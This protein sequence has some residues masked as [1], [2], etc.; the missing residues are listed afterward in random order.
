MNTY[1]RHRFQWGAPPR[2]QQRRSDSS[3]ASWG[4]MDVN[5]E[6]SWQPSCAVIVSPIGNWSLMQSTALNSIRI[7]TPSNRMRRPG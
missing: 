3:N 5:L 7:I 4:T 6:R 2:H 1:K